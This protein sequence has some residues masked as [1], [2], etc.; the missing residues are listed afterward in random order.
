MAQEEVIVGDTANDDVDTDT[1]EEAVQM[2]DSGGEI[3]LRQTT[4]KVTKYDGVILGSCEFCNTNDNTDTDEMKS[5]TIS[6]SGAVMITQA[7]GSDAVIEVRNNNNRKITVEDVMFGN[8]EHAVKVQSQSE[9]IVDSSSIATTISDTTYVMEQNVVGIANVGAYIEEKN[10]YY[11]GDVSTDENDIVEYISGNVGE[12][13]DRSSLTFNRKE[14]VS[15][16]NRVTLSNIHGTLTVAESGEDGNPDNNYATAEKAIQDAASGSTVK[17]N[18]L[19]S[20]YG[21]L[22]I[23]GK[24]VY[25]DYELDII[26]SESGSPT[27]DSIEFNYNGQYTVRELDIRGDVI[28]SAGVNADL[29]GNFWDPVPGENIIQKN[30]GVVS[31][32]KFCSDPQCTEPIDSMDTVINSDVSAQISQNGNQLYSAGSNN[33][34][35]SVDIDFSDI[36]QDDSSIEFYRGD[37]EIDAS[38]KDGKRYFVEIYVT[39]SD[40][41]RPEIVEEIN[42]DTTKTTDLSFSIKDVLEDLEV[43]EPKQINPKIQVKV[44]SSNG[45]SSTAVELDP[46]TVEL[47]EDSE[48]ASGGE[49]SSTGSITSGDLDSVTETQDTYVTRF[50]DG[51][52]DKP[53]EDNLLPPATIRDSSS[54]Q[55]VFG[56]VQDFSN[57]RKDTDNGATVQPTESKFNFG[58]SIESIPVGNDQIFHFHYAYQSD[59]S[60]TQNNINVDFVTDEGE[61]ISS[62]EL[63]VEPT[64]SS[65]DFEGSLR[66]AGTDALNSEQ[67]SIVLDEAIVEYINNG[68]NLNVIVSSDGE[69]AYDKSNLIIFSNY[70][71]TTDN[72]DIVEEYEDPADD[73][74]EEDDFAEATPGEFNLNLN[75]NGQENSQFGTYDVVGGESLGATISVENAGDTV[76]ERSIELNDVYEQPSNETV[77]PGDNSLDTDEESEKIHFEKDVTLSPGESRTYDISLDWESTEFGN[78][79]VNLYSVDENGDVQGDTD[80]NIPSADVYVQQKPTF[81]IVEIDVPSEELTYQNFDAKVTIRNIGDLPGTQTVKSEFGDWSDTREIELSGADPRSG[82]TSAEK[83]IYYNRLIDGENNEITNFPRREYAPANFV[84]ESIRI[85]TSMEVEYTQDPPYENENVDFDRGF[86]DTYFRPNSPF[87]TEAGVH[88]FTT[89]VENEYEPNEG[90]NF[91]KEL[92]KDVASALKQEKSE[93]IELYNL[94]IND[95][96]VNT[97]PTTSSG[98]FTSRPTKE[99][100]TVHASAFPYVRQSNKTYGTTFSRMKLAPSGDYGLQGTMTLP[101]TTSPQLQGDNY[102]TELRIDD[103]AATP[104]NTG[105]LRASGP[106][107]TV[108]SSNNRACHQQA[109]TGTGLI[110]SQPFNYSYATGAYERYKSTLPLASM[111]DGVDACSTPEDF[112]ALHLM[113][114]DSTEAGATSTNTYRHPAGDFEQKGVNPEHWDDLENGPNNTDYMFARVEISNRGSADR[115]TARF[116]IKS[117]R[118]ISDG[119]VGI[120]KDNMDVTTVMDMGNS[121]SSVTVNLGSEAY[122]DDTI[123]IASVDL[124]AETTEV[125]YVPIIVKNNVGNGG[126]HKI[127]VEPYSQDDYITKGSLTEDNESATESPITGEKHDPFTIPINVNTYG[128]VVLESFEPADDIK[129]GPKSNTGSQILENGFPNYGVDAVVNNV[130][131]DNDL[132]E[133]DRTNINGL[134]IDAYEGLN[135][136]SGL[137][138]QNYGIIRDSGTCNTSEDQNTDTAEF[139]TKYTNFGGEP[140]KIRSTTISQYDRNVN[141]QDAEIVDN[142]SKHPAADDSLIKVT[143]L[144]KFS[145]S[146]RSDMPFA[147]LNSDNPLTATNQGSYDAEADDVI[148]HAQYLETGADLEDERTKLVQPGETVEFTFETKFQEPGLYN[149]RTAPCRDVGAGPNNNYRAEPAPS[150]YNLEGFTGVPQTG[151]PADRYE[152]SPYNAN[153]VYT[154]NSHRM[155]SYLT[156]QYSDNIQGDEGEAQT[157]FFQDG[158][159]H[160]GAATRTDT[161]TEEDFGSCNAQTI[162][163]YDT[164]NPVADFRIADDQTTVKGQFK[165]STLSIDQVD[166]QPS[167]ATQEADTAHDRIQNGDNPFQVYEGGML[168]FDGSSADCDNCYGYNA[169]EPPSES[170]TYTNE[171]P[172]T[173][174]VMLSN[175][176]ELGSDTTIQY[177]HSNAQTG[178]IWNTGEHNDE[179]SVFDP[180]QV[181]RKDTDVNTNRMSTDNT[182]ITRM[183][184]EI[185]GSR[186]PNFGTEIPCIHIADGNPITHDHLDQPDR[187]CFMEA[188]LPPGIDGSTGSQQEV[189]AALAQ[190]Q[191]IAHRFN[192]VGTVPVSLQ[193]WDDPQLTQGDANTNKTTK[194]VEVIPDNNPPNVDLTKTLYNNKDYDREGGSTD[195]TYANIVFSIDHSG[196]VSDYT[197]GI[198]SATKN[199]VNNL[200]EKNA[201][202]LNA[203]GDDKNCNQIDEFKG[204]PSGFNNFINKKDF[205]RFDSCSDLPSYGTFYNAEYQFESADGGANYMILIGDGDSLDQSYETDKFTVISIY[206]DGAGDNRQALEDLA[207]KDADGNLMVYD[208]QGGDFSNAYAQ[209]E[210]EIALDTPAENLWHR[211]PDLF[212]NDIDYRNAPDNMETQFE[213]TY[214]GARMCFNATASDSEIGISQ[215]QWYDLGTDMYVINAG[216]YWRD[217]L[218][219]HGRSTSSYQEFGIDTRG[220]LFADETRDGN[221]R[222]ATFD[223]EANEPNEY[224]QSIDASGDTRTQSLFYEAWD[225]ASNSDIDEVQVD[226]KSDETDP[227][228]D[229]FDNKTLTKTGNNPDQGTDKFVWAAR[230]DRNFVGGEFKLEGYGTDPDGV[231]TACFDLDFDHIANPSPGMDEIADNCQGLGDGFYEDP[232]TDEVGEG[233]VSLGVNISAGTYTT[234]HRGG[235]FNTE[236]DT[237]TASEME[238]YHNS[239]TTVSEEIY[240]SD[241]HGN[242]VSTSLADRNNEIQIMIDETSPEKPNSGS[243]NCPPGDKDSWD[244]GDC[245]EAGPFPVDSQGPDGGSYLYEAEIVSHEW[246]GVQQDY[247][248]GDVSSCDND[249]QSVGDPEINVNKNDIE[250][251]FHT[252]VYVDTGAEVDADVSVES[253]GCGDDESSSTSADARITASGS[254]TFQ[255]TDVFGNTVTSEQFDYTVESEDEDED[256]T[257]CD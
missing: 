245:E 148:T 18:Q 133:T 207:D 34:L 52:E 150:H 241:W 84:P 110:R 138:S 154:G 196:S 92:D 107:S 161:V 167:S 172:Q 11:S 123:G 225:Y 236:T 5:F 93:D 166:V 46:I 56:D 171:L 184:W 32:S 136:K 144:Q 39:Q 213:D 247:C 108:Y 137:N 24:G 211:N 249:L 45:N 72:A 29:D 51:A 6:G 237:F 106:S 12:V 156:Y 99:Q 102:P 158:Y 57:A 40:S 54:K 113:R 253:A 42:S 140:K 68:G 131:R 209:I 73:P 202:V 15:E 61:S 85:G 41:N 192:Q 2:V 43:G 233:T 71:E 194:D 188:H 203:H 104:L 149:V 30:G 152:D 36:T 70:I 121:Q 23:D 182:R 210:G 162:M 48:L 222:C 240:L 223:E 232:G 170:Q 205:E 257:D 179:G 248:W 195:N 25:G 115:A 215:E 212:E 142:T 82:Q 255:I 87:G 200:N 191:T 19:S 217:T 193:V 163:V 238:Y 157:T 168:F 60:T 227:V 59:N 208:E 135:S 122:R 67:E 112:T 235:G 169:G 22:T 146:S 252:N 230:E 243:A 114:F 183:D 118:S 242:Y 35:G 62:Q 160:T 111:N 201:Y 81:E 17:L 186:D 125:V 74:N 129:V 117:N 101:E 130:C 109:N 231:G 204:D 246:D 80:G 119:A 224:S 132:A 174:P 164:T 234:D 206:F 198:K 96:E 197:G 76:I 83:E 58:M 55:N 86:N 256:D 13:Q 79:T 49:T 44:D 190:N 254:F 165:N 100:A 105:L 229:S 155:D 4:D 53:L 9:V 218:S 78:H 20:S 177:D 27:V 91:D 219:S 10:V 116:R 180:D 103:R 120:G 69:L 239:N 251:K 65:D 28:A 128:D 124:P 31:V 181:N 145:A 159:W 98:K 1:L 47:T 244:D 26:G 185:A 147:P 90:D 97:N 94:Q 221:R 75:I 8:A 37:V 3:T 151:S 189:E 173:S 153:D 7:Q 214:E 141:R 139:T 38:V 175:E 14:P 50:N 127:S 63:T 220:D 66:N 228:I 226:V 216:E 176:F 199:F 143:Q 33:E 126:I 64:V 134:S 88:Q 77:Y 178:D 187:H 21:T 89:T 95:F 250:G 16:L